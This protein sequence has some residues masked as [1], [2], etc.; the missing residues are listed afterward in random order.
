[1][2]MGIGMV[3]IATLFPLGLLKLRDASRLTRSAYLAES[4]A[5]D[6]A[7][8]GLLNKTSFQYADSINQTVNWTFPYWYV[9]SSF[10]TA[11][12]YDPF[13]QDTPSY[14]GDPFVTGPPVSYLGVT[15][16]RGLG[17]PVA[18]DPLWRWQTGIYL[19]P[20]NQTTAESR[21]AS[22][23]GFLRLDPDG[24]T[25]SAYGLQRITNFNG[26]T[27]TGNIAIMPASQFVPSIFVSP[28]DI[29][30]QDSA[31]KG[32]YPMAGSLGLRTTN[33]ISDP[34]SGTSVD[35]TPSSLVPD[36]SQASNALDNSPGFRSSTGVTPGCS[37]AVR[38]RKGYPA[39]HSTATS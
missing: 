34:I 30:W 24:G 13:A 17:L 32:L 16:S 1:M 6:L 39:R 10:T 12:S 37:Q 7:T 14:G 9:S 23:I 15:A 3:S 38:F 33:P 35:S 4:A 5:A 8:R 29:V 28:E 2:I 21:F 31:H 19:D 26:L 25:A 22:G 27:A 36:L 18:Y 20:I 11:N